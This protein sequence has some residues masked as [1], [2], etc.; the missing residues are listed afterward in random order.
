M[1]SAGS[2]RKTAEPAT[3]VSAPAVAAVMTGNPSAAEGSEQ[4]RADG[5]ERRQC[6]DAGLPGEAEPEEH[7]VAGHVGDEHVAELEVADRIDEPG[8]GGEG[9][10]QH[11]Q[12]GTAAPP[13]DGRGRHDDLRCVRAFARWT[14]PITLGRK[15][16]R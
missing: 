10:K 3:N 6:R 16:A 13:I 14:L 4:E 8:D 2:P 1:L 12:G 9:Q 7:H 5:H 15:C 11:G